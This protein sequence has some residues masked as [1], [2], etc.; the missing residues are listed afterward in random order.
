MEV[1]LLVRIAHIVMLQIIA[2]KLQKDSILLLIKRLPH[3]VL[4]VVKFVQVLAEL[5]LKLQVT[6]P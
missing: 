5:V 6:M 1:L 2:H 3:Y 4:Q